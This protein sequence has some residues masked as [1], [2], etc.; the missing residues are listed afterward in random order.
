[1]FTQNQYKSFVVYSFMF[2]VIISTIHDISE[3]NFIFLTS[4]KETEVVIIDSRYSEERRDRLKQIQHGYKKLVY[5]P[6][7]KRDGQMAYDFLSGQNTGLMYADEPWCLCIGDNWELKPDFFAKLKETIELF[8]ELYENHFVIRP[9]ELEQQD[10]D[11]RWVS[12]VR[13]NQRY[14]HLPCAPVG[15]TGVRRQFPIITCGAI[16]AHQEAWFT[17]NGFDERYDV[18]GGWYDNEL[19]YRF[20]I[21]RYP[22]ILDQQAMIYRISHTSSFSTQGRDECKKIFDEAIETRWKGT[23]YA[24]NQFDL[25]ELHETMVKEKERYIL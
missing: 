25:R 6:P 21:M 3:S 5:A 23:I 17:L 1:M 20:I 4:C 18:G 10:N 16:V 15:T 24:P 8:T 19:F 22:I 12:F 11:V 9:I 14:F 7:K 2:S 13:F